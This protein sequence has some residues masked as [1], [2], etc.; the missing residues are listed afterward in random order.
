MLADAAGVLQ[1][2]GDVL[3]AIAWPGVVLVLVYLLFMTERGRKAVSDLTSRFR[4]VRG[5][6]FEI[7]LTE[8]AAA[9]TRGFTDERFRQFRALVAS[10]FDRQST[11]FCVDEK[12][13]RLIADHIIPLIRNWGLGE[14]DF[15]CTVHVPDI[16]FTQALYQ[17]LD[18]YGDAPGKRGR[19][20]SERFG[21]VGRAWRLSSPQVEGNVSTQPAD[22]VRDWGMTWKEASGA[23]R[24]R[25]SFAAI[26]LHDDH[27]VRVGVAYLDSEKKEAFGTMRDGRLDERA[28]QLN[29]ALRL[30]ASNTGLTSALAEMMAEL[31]KR[32]PL[33]RVF[34]VGE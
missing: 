7:E 13:Q 30:G 14:G 9:Q 20:F 25:T 33:I 29:E 21:I 34:E 3:A 24:G 10:E 19:A 18:Y 16:L 2:I 6:G 5:P 28:T 23:G 4:R 12:H 31:R 15:R 11:I 26:P 27:Q 1:G 8:E 22:L 17:L 32:A